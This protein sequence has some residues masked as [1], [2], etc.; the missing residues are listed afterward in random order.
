VDPTVVK[1][2]IHPPTDST[3]LGDDIQVITGLLQEGNTLTPA[4]W[5][6]FVDQ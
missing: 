6:T 1:T 5:Y 4:R 3:L 2:H